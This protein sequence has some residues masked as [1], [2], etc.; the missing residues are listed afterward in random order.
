MSL[1]KLSYIFANQQRFKSKVLN[2]LKHTKAIQQY[3]YTE[4]LTQVSYT[5]KYLSIF[6][7]WDEWFAYTNHCELSS[8]IR[9]WFYLNI[10]KFDK[11]RRLNSNFTKIKIS[12][13][14]SNTFL[15]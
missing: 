8:I 4:W 15:I 13:K 3:K 11:N 9:F 12:K 2:T 7:Y 1:E 10:S 6:K 14:D 5:I